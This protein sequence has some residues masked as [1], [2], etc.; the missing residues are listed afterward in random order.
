MYIYQFLLSSL[1]CWD[2]NKKGNEATF[3]GPSLAVLCESEARSDPFHH[4]TS[5]T[6]VS[7]LKKNVPMLCSGTAL[8]SPFP[9]SDFHTWLLF[10][11]KANSRLQSSPVQT[12]SAL[13]NVLRRNYW[14]NSMVQS[15][16]WV[17]LS[18]QWS[19]HVHRASG[20]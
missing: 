3:L 4:Q 11:L 13:S 10:Q 16:R 7:Y 14:K 12:D 17:W 5:S 20:I 18:R 1:F 9:N 15:I 6:F 8:G 19:R 2:I